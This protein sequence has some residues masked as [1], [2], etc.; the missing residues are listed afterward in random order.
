V[1][2]VELA[3]YDGRVSPA[4]KVGTIKRAKVLEFKGVL[5]A[6]TPVR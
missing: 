3:K 4:T 5:V 1:P 2:V 6:H